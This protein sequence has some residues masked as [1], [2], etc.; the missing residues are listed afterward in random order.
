MPVPL[1]GAILRPCLHSWPSTMPR[2]QIILD[3]SVSRPVPDVF[4]ALSN[5]N[6]MG[7][8][9]GV[10][11]KRIKDGPAGDVNG[12]GSVRQLGLAGPLAVHETVTAVD[13]LKRI[14]YFVSKG[15][16]P[17]KGHQGQIRFEATPQGT[18]VQ[19]DIGYNMPP[20]IGGIVSRVLTKVLT[21]AL[22]SLNR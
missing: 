15:G 7:K 5:H 19:W 12:A 14:D 21:R 3:E 1:N 16:A 17:M 4:E 22:R 11:V 18:R 10:P 2:Y 9:F 8:L 6:T 20:V 13:P